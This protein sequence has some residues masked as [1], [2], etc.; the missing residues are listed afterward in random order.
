[1][2]VLA[3]SDIRSGKRPTENDFP[4]VLARKHETWLQSESIALFSNAA[5]LW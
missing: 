5:H 1:M 2:P 3:A 4:S